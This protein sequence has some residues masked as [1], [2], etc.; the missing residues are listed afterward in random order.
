[1]APPHNHLHLSI[2]LP[3]SLSTQHHRRHRRRCSTSQMCFFNILHIISVFPAPDVTHNND[4]DISETKGFVGENCVF[5]NN[6]PIKKE[7]ESTVE[8]ERD[9][10]I[11]HVGDQSSGIAIDQNGYS[12]QVVEF[13]VEKPRD[14]GYLGLLIEAAQLI[15]GNESEPDK[16]PPS[17]P[18]ITSSKIVTGKEVKRKQQRW[19]ATAEAE[20]YAEYED[21]SP[22]VKS[23]RGRNQVL[24]FKYRDSVVEP[25]V[26]WTSACKRRS[27]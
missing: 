27:K 26:R 20:W 9:S 1:M 21:T 25:L 16:K 24:P 8:D 10:G 22:V 18:Q 12:K 7:S 17:H 14:E 15:L 3:L 11:S 23:K 6:D 2:P 4:D 13:E 19:T 5:E